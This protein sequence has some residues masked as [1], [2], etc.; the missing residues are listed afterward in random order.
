MLNK[1][2]LIGNVGNDPEIKKLDIGQVATFSLATTEH[3]KD[4]N[5]NPIEQVE[6]IRL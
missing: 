3:Y 5:G 2:E 6:C 1:V 4:K